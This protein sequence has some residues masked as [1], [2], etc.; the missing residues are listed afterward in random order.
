MSEKNITAP[1]ACLV[2]ISI[3][4]GLIMVAIKKYFNAN[5]NIFQIISYTITCDVIIVTVFSRYLWKLKCFKGWLVPFPDL[6]GTWLGCIH[7]DWINPETGA[8]APAIPV[9]LTINQSFFSINCKMQT[10]EMKSYSMA[11][12]F[13]ID[14]DKRVKQL[15]YIYV[16]KSR[17]T[18]SDR[19]PQH[20]GAIIFDVTEKG[21]QKKLSGNYW[22]SRKTKGEINLSFHSHEFLDELPEDMNSHPVTEIENIH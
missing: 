2:I 21:S 17:A 3:I 14:A 13:N 16:S 18:L 9:M 20:D 11:G 8:K 22:T 10:P 6:T 19:S 15:S 4:V 1:I 7:S 5:F 12:G